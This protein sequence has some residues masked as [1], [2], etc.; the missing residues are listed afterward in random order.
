MRCFLGLMMAAASLLTL[1]PAHVRAMDGI[2]ACLVFTQADASGLLQTD[3][4]PG[5]SRGAVSPA[6]GSC[7]Y[8][9]SRDGDLYGLTLVHCTDATIAGE[10]IY[11]S[12]A[13]VMA[14]QLRARQDSQSASALLRILP[15]LGDEAFWDGSALWMRKGSHLVRVTPDPYVPGPFA[16]MSAAS[17]AKLERSLELAL[18]AAGTISAR[19]P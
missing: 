17:A 5:V 3:V 12:A 19:L 16:D 8:T 6:G 1:A 2:D 4:S 7:R 13:D 18:A 15:N 14:R 11:G 9:F 10:G